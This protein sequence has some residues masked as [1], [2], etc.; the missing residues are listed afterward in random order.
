MEL[1]VD[2]FAAAC[3]AAGTELRFCFCLME[4]NA[5]E[6]AGIAV[7]QLAAGWP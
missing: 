5:A 1:N 6:L 3:D 4:Q 2:R 7:E